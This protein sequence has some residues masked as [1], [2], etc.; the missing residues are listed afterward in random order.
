MIF[1]GAEDVTG[2]PNTKKENKHMEYQM[3]AWGAFVND[4]E[5]GLSDVMGWP[6]YGSEKK[7]L[8]RLAYEGRAGADFVRPDVYDRECPANRSVAEAQGAF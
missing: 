3:R 7:S 1:G 5:S 4:P 8:V 6:E 2:L